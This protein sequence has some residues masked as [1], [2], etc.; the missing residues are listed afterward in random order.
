MSDPTSRPETL[1]S[2]TSAA[3]S[4]AEAMERAALWIGL[5]DTG[6]LSDEVLADRVAELVASRDGA[7]GFF[8]VGL[9]GEAPL[10]DRLPEP[11]LAALRQAGA[12]VVD[13]T[14]RNLAMST[15]MAL[16]HQR[17]G[18][19]EHQAGSEQVQRRSTEL[20]RHLE[21]AAVKARL[22][23]LLAATERRAAAPVTVEEAEGTPVGTVPSLAEQAVEEDSAF[24]ARW[25]YDDEQRR[26]ISAAIEAVAD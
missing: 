5:W 2:G 24:L 11:L 22:E 23:T 20:L 8:V 12:G 26:A 17:S 4:F 16:H 1:P 7:R 18:D 10:L 21:P 13:L 15:A 9:T 6:E 19:R 14:A 25:G 3:P